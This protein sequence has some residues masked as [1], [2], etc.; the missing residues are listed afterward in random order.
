[1]NKM[2]SYTRQ[3]FTGNLEINNSSINKIKRSKCENNLN[4]LKFF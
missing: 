4:E 1:M 2:P 3:F